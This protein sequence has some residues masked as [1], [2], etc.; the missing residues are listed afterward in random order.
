MSKAE[1]LHVIEQVPRG[2]LEAPATRLHEVLPGPTLMH[3]PGRRAEPLFVS[4]LLHG[5]ETGG[6][7]AIQRV[8]AE[9][10]DRALP[11]ALSVFFGNVHAGRAGVRRLEDQADFNRAWPGSE[12][13]TGTVGALLAEV[14]EAMRLRRPF[15]SIDLHN[16]TGRNPYFACVTRTD[17]VTLQLASLFSR[18]VVVF[19][20]P[21]GTQASAFSAL[22][23]AVAC[24]CGQS[25]DEL[26]VAH[27]AEF[28]AGALHLAQLPV[29]PVGKGDLHLFHSVARVRVADA[30]TFSFDG[31]PAALRFG[32]DLEWFNFRELAP[33]TVLAQCAPGTDVC[34]EVRDEHDRDVA[35][36]YLEREAGCVQLRRGVMPAMLTRDARAVRLDCLCYFMERLAQ[37]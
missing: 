32:E 19:R 22:C 11:R 17:N 14:L 12:G 26:G 9:H 20:R 1:S 28:V 27:A 33:G 31:S 36:I 30:V 8:L 15:A 13:D 4:V 10:R 6:L 35:S 5:D 3:L 16:N 23:P 29:H 34:L 2:L 37:P 21:L 24:E 7:R 18:T 25:I